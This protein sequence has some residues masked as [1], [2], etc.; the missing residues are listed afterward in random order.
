M[1][2][3]YAILSKSTA[4]LNLHELLPKGT[5]LIDLSPVAAHLPAFLRRLAV[6]LLVRIVHQ[7]TV[8]E[9]R[10]IGAL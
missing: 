9:I 7:R 3:R 5:F 10:L 1:M 4:R 8:H 2:C 6:A